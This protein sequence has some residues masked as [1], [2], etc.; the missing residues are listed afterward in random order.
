MED[1][2]AVPAAF[3]CP[4]TQEQMVDPVVALDGHSY[5]RGA[6][7]DWFRRGRLSS[8]CT[9]ERLA[10]DQLVPNHSLRKAME[11]RRDEQPMAID[12]ARLAVSEELLGE[13]S[14]G[15]VIAGTLTTG[16]RTLRVAV[17]TL[18]A[19]TREQERQAFKDEFRNHTHAARHCHGVCLLYGLCE[20]QR[21]PWQ[22]RLCIV[23]KRY[24][25]SLET[26]IAAAGGTGL[27]EARV[28]RYAKSLSRTLQE[29][30]ESGLVLQDIKPPNILLDAYDQPV[31]ADFG[32]AVI[33][34]TSDHRGTS[35]KGTYNYMAPEAFEVEGIGKHTD[36]WAL[37]CV[38]VEMRT[39]QR[40]WADMQ[41]QQIMMA[42]CVQQRT[43][44]VPEDAPAAALLCQCFERRPTQRPT[45]ADL[46]HA[47]ASDV[48]GG[49]ESP[50]PTLARRL[51]DQEAITEEVTRVN[52]RLT[53]ENAR[54]QREVEDR[55]REERALQGNVRQRTQ[56]NARL[57]Q[58]LLQQERLQYHRRLDA[59]LKDMRQHPADAKVQEKGCKSLMI[60][61]R[62]ADKKVKIGAGGGV[63]AIVKA[64]QGEDWGGGRGGGHRAGDGRAPRE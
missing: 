32:I 1:D 49:V 25:Q 12:P 45:A 19:M 48:R 39:G 4:I 61:A 56:E 33:L 46:A 16:R 21:A 26:A 36:V 7:Q 6:I 13:G 47:F 60:L 62:N 18:P 52:S 20:M 15:R 27:D 23:M 54:L 3:V 29:L 8:P 40:P 42:V 43:P 55:R 2:D 37:A 63:E 11:Q 38:I 14:H 57:T 24:E 50:S 17:K 64:I 35:I 51:E 10:S 30:H 9:N 41:E 58:Q 31:F 34:Q 5:S 22:G 53:Q 44:Q 59:V 28:C